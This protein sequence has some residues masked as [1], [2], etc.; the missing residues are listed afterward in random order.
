MDDSSIMMVDELLNFVKDERNFSDG[1]HSLNASDLF[2]SDSPCSFGSPGTTYS[3]KDE[4]FNSDV[5]TNS[6][7]PFDPNDFFND[8]YKSEVSYSSFSSPSNR[9][10]PSPSISNGSGSD[11]ST[12]DYLQINQKSSKINL[13]QTISPQ[14]AQ[15]ISFLNQIITPTQTSVTNAPVQVIQGTLIPIQTVALTSSH[16]TMITN[17]NGTQTKK[18][19]I[20]PKPVTTA[21]IQKPV[22][23]PK[24]IV[25]SANDYNSLMQKCKIQ[26]TNGDQTK[27]QPI[28]LKTTTASAIQSSGKIAPSIN[29][30]IKT[31]AMQ[32]QS[33]AFKENERT[34]QPIVVHRPSFIKPKDTDDRAVKKQMR[35]IKNRE[36]A[37]L[38]RKK[39]KEYVTS[40]EN[41]ISDLTKE[42]K[43]LKN[44]SIFDIIH[45]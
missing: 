13:T 15:P 8:N 21:S 16:N 27:I 17:T 12:Y 35:M 36:S 3:P 6:D 34:N 25:L 33:I 41:R 38:S 30:P 10:T 31:N 32:L 14:I 37:C 42:N 26:Q 2:N 40:L 45:N 9:D 4:Q 29:M 28:T 5:D 7:T 24:T 23:K 19:K 18:I 43:Q 11:Q 39:K 20:Q 44:V 1:I 22:I